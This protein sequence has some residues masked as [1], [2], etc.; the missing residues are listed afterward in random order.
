MPKRE[1]PRLMDWFE[2]GLLIT[3]ATLLFA[4][5]ASQ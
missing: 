1:K 4:V 3:I 2:L 5:M